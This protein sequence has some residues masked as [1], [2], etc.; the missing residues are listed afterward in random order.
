[1]CKPM[2]HTYSFHEWNFELNHTGTVV[3]MSE[4]ENVGFLLPDGTYPL[5]ILGILDSLSEARLVCRTS[6]PNYIDSCK[7]I[8]KIDERQHQAGLPEGKVVKKRSK[9]EKL[10]E[11]M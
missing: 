8:Q 11:Y 4:R 5:T 6:I 9:K 2:L 1:M 10:D 3:G 7:T